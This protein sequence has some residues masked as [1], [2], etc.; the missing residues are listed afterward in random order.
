MRYPKC[1]ECGEEINPNKYEDCEKAYLTKDGT[2]CKDHFL[3][4]LEANYTLDEIASALGIGV[5]YL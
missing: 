3:C 4:Y 2:L 5:I 1:S